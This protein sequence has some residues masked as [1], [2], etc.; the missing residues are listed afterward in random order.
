MSPVFSMILIVNINCLEI[1]NLIEGIK[2]LV[3]NEPRRCSLGQYQS[4]PP[5]NLVLLGVL[6]LT[7][8]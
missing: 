3:A 6:C 7:G 8:G 4:P 2:H 5:E 1:T